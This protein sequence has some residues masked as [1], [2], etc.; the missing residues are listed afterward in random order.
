M[1]NLSKR[2][3]KDIGEIGYYNPLEK[4]L[5][6]KKAELVKAINNGAYPTNT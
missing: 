5:V 2:D 6:F 1:E 4:A 3:G